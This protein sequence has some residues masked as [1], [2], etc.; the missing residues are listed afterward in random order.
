MAKNSTNG[1]ARMPAITR[2]TVVKVDLR[3]RASRPGA[4]AVGTDAVGPDAVGTDAVRVD[5]VGTDAVGTEAVGADAVGADVAGAAAA[6]VD[7]PAAEQG[8]CLDAFI[9]ALSLVIANLGA[10][11]PMPRA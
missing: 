7:G 6:D 8:S 3:R 1:A 11:L 9:A 10:A 2:T 4:D 5:A